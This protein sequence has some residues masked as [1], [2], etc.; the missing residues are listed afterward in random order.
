MIVFPEPAKA[1]ERLAVEKDRKVTRARRPFTHKRE[2]VDFHCRNVSPC[3]N[4][5]AVPGCWVLR[6]ILKF[7]HGSGGDNQCRSLS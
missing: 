1:E 3:V 2:A 5:V 6:A 4:H 7:V